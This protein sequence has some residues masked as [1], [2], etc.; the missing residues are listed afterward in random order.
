M[1]DVNDPDRLTIITKKRYKELL[2]IE[3]EYMHMEG[4]A[5]FTPK[6]RKEYVDNLVNKYLESRDR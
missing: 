5:R 4:Q 1:T 6:A 2:A 3:W